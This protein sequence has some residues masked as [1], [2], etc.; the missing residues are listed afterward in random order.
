MPMPLSPGVTQGA[1]GAQPATAKPQA[2]AG[3]VSTST[4]TPGTFS[5]PQLVEMF[6]KWHEESFDNRWVFERQWMRNIWYVLNRQWIYFDT[7]RGQWQDKRLA[8][9]VP[10]PV[11]NICKEA[12][13]S[14]RAN[15]A[16]INYGA[17][18]RPVG[19]ALKN[20]VT[21]GVA[22]DYMPILH[23]SHMM[24][25]VMNEFDFWQ[26]VTGNAW[27]HTCVNY[28]RANGMI[29][30]AYE[31]CMQC[32]QEFP[33]NQIA[34]AGQKCPSCGGTQFQPAI[35]PATGQPK[36]T[37][38]PMSKGI[39]MAL[40]P[41]EVAFPLTYESYDAAP[42]TIR[43]RWRDKAYYEQHPEFATTY[44]KTLNFG[45][46]PTD[47][48]M[49]VF[50]SL[51]FQND[52]GMSPAWFGSGGGMSA[53]TEGIT[54]YDVWIKPCNDF[55]EGQ[56]IR[57]AGEQNPVVIHS[58]LES[59]PGPLP[60]HDAAGN[61][62][63]TFSHAS[64]DHV[65]GRALGS[66]LLD[67][68]IQKQD[69]L[70]QVDS[71]ML[72]IIMRT[73][74]PIWLEPKGAEVEKFTGEP[75]LV[76]KWNPL[77]AGGTAKPERI[78]GENIP[79]TMFQYRELIKREAEELS[80]TYDLM[81]GGKPVGVEAYSSLSLL[82]EIGQS[83]HTSG[84]KS[85]GACYKHWAKC[86]LEIEREFGP[87]TR[88]RAIMG[89]SKG[90]VFETFKKTDLGGAMEIVIEDG[91]LKPKSALGE[92]AA[93]EHLSQLQ[94][95]NPS[96][97]DQVYAIYQKFGQTDLLPGLD[98]QVQEAG[99]NMEQFEKAFSDP[100]IVQQL[101]VVMQQAQMSGM[102]PP[103]PLRYKRWYNPT[104]H[105]QEL[106]KWCV[107]DAG[108]KLMTE[109]PEAEGFVDQYLTQIDMALML[110][111]QGMMDSNGMP[112]PG[113][114]PPGGAQPNGKQFG[115]PGQPQQGG[116]VSPKQGGGGAGRSMANSNQNSAGAG[117]QSS[118][119]AGTSAPKQ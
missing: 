91:T 115:P 84:M 64:Y 61:P 107:S 42:Y 37:Q 60:Y 40:S 13:Q 85:R 47:R 96:D 119:S 116:N 66:G 12:V 99:L 15:F 45:K 72:M 32:Q 34:D 53:K 106:I 1:P 14:I 82:E 51:P 4:P 25:T 98:A 62:I 81:K 65:G 86:A 94:L 18:C 57:F 75:G 113:F 93:I 76:V 58:E 3:Q 78:P 44:A 59:L 79:A 2:S 73:A 117:P 21:A 26:L 70:N 102:P 23:E 100:Q 112:P 8:K 89:P 67:P 103:S 97:P 111:Q 39:T 110:M 29:T 101:Q 20:I 108:R 10:R 56:V 35:D 92:R 33:Q 88:T 41:F 22:D 118:S 48:T 5:D 17:S 46:S 38:Q 69:Q 19:N 31:Q 6:K 83:R 71:L 49:Q 87:E 77:V 109:H 68:I 80:G 30:I 27:L 50:K 24:D 36:Q 63:F 104:I 105:R 28:E 9:W 43:M 90:W 74:N 55:P 11:T 52:L 7:T 54:E 95:L 114:A 16:K